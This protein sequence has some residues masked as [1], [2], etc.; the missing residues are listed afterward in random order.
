MTNNQLNKSV[1][2]LNYVRFPLK[3]L[4]QTWASNADVVVYAFMLNRFMFF[5][6]LNKEYYE[7]IDQIA[8]ACSQS[9]ATVKRTLS[10]LAE[11]GHILV[12]KAKVGVGVSNR[13]IVKDIYCVMQPEVKTQTSIQPDED[14]SWF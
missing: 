8:L 11:H 9:C 7:N 4:S 14:P 12:S 6:G 1:E 10:K 13:Y 5:K 3:M 2:T